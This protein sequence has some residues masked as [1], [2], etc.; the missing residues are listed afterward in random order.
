MCIYICKCVHVCVCLCTSVGICACTCICTFVCVTCM[1]MFVF[2][3]CVC[4]HVSVYACLCSLCLCICVCVCRGTLACLGGWS[5]LEQQCLPSWQHFLQKV[6]MFA[7]LSVAEHGSCT[8]WSQAQPTRGSEWVVLGPFC[9][10]SRLYGVVEI[11]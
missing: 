8:P 2:A 6:W 11:L 1:C 7:W 9:T 4:L 10:I 5:L 3:C